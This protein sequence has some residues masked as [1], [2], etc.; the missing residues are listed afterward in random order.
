[1][2]GIAGNEATARWGSKCFA[3][4]CFVSGDVS[5]LVGAFLG[6]LRR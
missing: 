6:F 1:M 4:S 5:G 2:F 3:H